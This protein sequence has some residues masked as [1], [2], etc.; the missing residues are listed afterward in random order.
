[1]PPPDKLKIKSKVQFVYREFQ[2]LQRRHYRDSVPR[3]WEDKPRSA[4]PEIRQGLPFLKTAALL[5]TSLRCLLC[6]HDHKDTVCLSPASGSGNSVLTT[7]GGSIPKRRPLPLPRFPRLAIFQCRKL[8]QR[9]SF[10][11]SD[12][13]V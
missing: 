5:C 4:Y 9:E 3:D 2:S 8:S 10:F 7:V 1:M 11:S 6:F 12:P 13:S